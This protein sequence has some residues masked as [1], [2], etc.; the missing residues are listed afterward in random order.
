MQKVF[1]ILKGKSLNNRIQFRTKRDLSTEI[2]QK[3]LNII[4][5]Q[6]IIK[7]T[8]VPKKREK[9]IKQHREYKYP[10][11]KSKDL[12]TSKGN[13]HFP[14]QK[15]LNRSSQSL[16]RRIP[17]NKI[18]HLVQRQKRKSIK[19]IKTEKQSQDLKILPVKLLSLKIKNNQV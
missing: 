11:L 15:K 7:Y 5:R 8:R 18:L 3:L 6:P 9:K 19:K 17:S 16:N 2:K 4:F 14:K 10:K 12:K 13:Q 1:R